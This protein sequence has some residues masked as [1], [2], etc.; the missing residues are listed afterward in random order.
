[1]KQASIILTTTNSRRTAV[2]LA[3]G[4]VRR[5]LAACVSIIDI[6]KSIYKW[7]GRLCKDREFLLVIKTRT[8]LAGKASKQI[9]SIHP[10]SVPE[11]AVIKVTKLNDD[12]LR[13]LYNVT[14]VMPTK[15][16]RD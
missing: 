1:M 6:A 16:R 11:I 13:W 9:K 4:L 7:K 10:Y 12:Y 8:V 14:E 2:K 5:G 3:E 15:N